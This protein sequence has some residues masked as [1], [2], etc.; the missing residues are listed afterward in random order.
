M[1]SVERQSLFFMTLS[2]PRI[3]EDIS[4]SPFEAEKPDGDWLVG[5]G[6]HYFKGDF[7]TIR[8]LR[9]LSNSSTASYDDA[10]LTYQNMSPSGL[11]RDAFVAWCEHRRTDIES[12][13]VREGDRHQL[14]FRRILLSAPSSDRIGKFL[15]PIFSWPAFLVLAGT[16]LAA[17]LLISA[18]GLGTTQTIATTLPLAIITALLGVFIHELGHTTAAV[19]YGAKQGGIGIG[20]YWIW[21][22]L[23]SDVRHTWKLSRWRR[24]A[25][26]VGG[27]YFQALYVAC[28]FVLYRLTGYS[29]LYAACG[30]SLFLMATTLNPVFKFDGYWIATDLTNSV[31]LHKTIRLTLTAML[32]GPKSEEWRNHVSRSRVYL[33]IGFLLVGVSYLAYVF[34]LMLPIV[35]ASASLVDEAY[36]AYSASSSSMPSPGMLGDAFLGVLGVCFFSLLIAILLW[37]TCIEIYSVASRQPAS[38]TTKERR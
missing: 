17:N 6:E 26:S 2:P 4:F 34:G 21:P 8:V 20:L 25:V 28:L 24:L 13:Q 23:Y 18:A 16:I 15:A 7:E 12:L 38:K 36:N 29:A 37:R 27:L 10:Y 22:A 35:A 3:P 9:A 19:R 33:A 1:G 11:D 31:N 30:I 5:S 32:R 14:K